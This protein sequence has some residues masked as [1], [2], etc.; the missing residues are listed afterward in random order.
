MHFR[1]AKELAMNTTVEEIKFKEETPV[2]VAVQPAKA[3]KTWK[4]RIPKLIGGTVIAAA[5]A[6]GATVWFSS[7]VSTD[8]A[9]VDG[10]LVTISPKITGHVVEVLVTDN[11]QVKAGDVLARI[12]NR[13][14]VAR[15]AQAKASV[16]QAASAARS[17]GVTVPLTRNTTSAATATASAQY[18]AAEADFVRARVSVDQA[19]QSEIAFAEANVQ[20][21]RANNDRAQSDLIRMKPLADKAEISQL[22]YD[23]YVNAARAADGELKAAEEKLVS[24]RKQAEIQQAS[25]AAAKARVDQAQAGLNETVADE[26]KVDVRSAD[27]GSSLAQVEAAK[28]NLDAAELQLSYTEIKA[29]V[30][31]VVTRKTVELGQMVQPGQGLLVLVPMNDVW[32]TANFKETQLK[33]VHAGQAAEIKVDMYGQKIRGRVDS[34]SEATGSRLSLLPP[35]NATGNFVKVVQRIP[36]K[37]LV[38]PAD[39]QKFPLRVGMNVEASINTQQ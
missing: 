27:L 26:K 11:Q 3:P 29:P 19:S 6:T 1:G 20:T 36:V 33:G 8:D 30:G 23:A 34:I 22:Q 39:L 21:K 18:A 38:D 13:D 17:A 15:V 14:F 31:G 28:A 12:D 9:Q 4:Q 10:H 25:L 7:V 5:L 32:V 37:I 16:E 35:E 2:A 24:A